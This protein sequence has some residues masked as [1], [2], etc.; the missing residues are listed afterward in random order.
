M[1]A[2]STRRY[3]AVV[4][5]LLVGIV[6]ASSFGLLLS[7]FE[8][9]YAAQPINPETD[10]QQVAAAD[11]RVINL[12]KRV[13]QNPPGVGRAIDTAVRTG[14]YSGT[15]HPGELYLIADEDH[16]FAVYRG[17]YYRWNSTTNE[18]TS[19]VTIRLRSVPAASV[20]D[21]LATPYNRASP[22]VKRVIRQGNA[23]PGKTLRTGLVK[24]G[25]TY[26][27]VTITNEVSVFAHII[28]AP[29]TL[30]L[31]TVGRA[32]VVVATGLLILL[33]AEDR[34][35]HPLMLRSSLVFAVAVVP[36]VWALTTVGESGSVD[37]RYI[38]EPAAGFCVALGAFAGVALRQGATRTLATVT[39]IVVGM[40]VIGAGVLGG[41]VAAIGAL[42]G[43]FIVWVASL[44]LVPYGY[45]FSSES[46]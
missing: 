12:N 3:G 4:V 18:N 24:R 23:T 25:T 16:S 13:A 10:T 37:F 35:T 7:D 30:V 5:L 38:V 32:Y 26:Y 19:Q 40:G 42:F 14:A 11:D 39:G 43:L 15:N 1:T 28:L 22:G 36:V 2:S 21:T 34:D 41:P 46:K 20:A 33:W 31:K 9:R 44:P 17:A 8:S 6:F 29:I 27:A 45:Y